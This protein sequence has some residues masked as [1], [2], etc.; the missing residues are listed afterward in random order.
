MGLFHDRRVKAED[1]AWVVIGRVAWLALPVKP[2]IH[3]WKIRDDT[4]VLHHE[5]A[6]MG[7]MTPGDVIVPIPS[8]YHGMILACAH[9]PEINLMIEEGADLSELV[10]VLPQKEVVARP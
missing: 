2:N 3:D 6:P 5:I 7:M 1:L 4:V 10:A 8:R 9:S